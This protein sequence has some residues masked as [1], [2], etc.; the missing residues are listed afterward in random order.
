MCALYRGAN[1]AQAS[2]RPAPLRAV[3][4]AGNA[5]TPS[6]APLGPAAARPSALGLPGAP[7]VA[8]HIRASIATLEVLQQHAPLLARWAAELALRL[9]RGGRL[10]VAGNGGSAA[11]AQHLTAE[12]VGRYDGD[13]RPFSAIALHGDTSAVT[14]IGNDYG[15]HEVFARQVR[16]HGRPGDVLVLLSTSGKSQNL[17]AAAGA[18]REQGILTWALT[19][20]GPN[21]LSVVVDEALVLDGR[22]CHVQESQLVAIHALCECFDARIAGSTAGSVSGSAGSREE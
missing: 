7:E 5:A 1:A 22:N 4:A 10:L 20:S 14:A 11:E 12:L 15:Y 17:I 6:A 9:E 16:A 2:R 19:G 18:A 8:E 3:P 13:R 21:P